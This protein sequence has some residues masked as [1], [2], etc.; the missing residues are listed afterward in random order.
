VA[1][2][3]AAGI[4]LP[5]QQRGVGYVVQDLALFPHMTVRDNIAFPL[6]GQPHAT[7]EHRVDELIDTM[8]LAGTADRRPAYISGGQQQRVALARALA[9]NPKLLLLDEPFS[10]LDSELQAAL[11]RE[12]RALQRR[13]QMTVLLVTH[14]IDEAFSM[15]DRVVA[16]HD[17]RVSQ[18]GTRE[19]VF[20][21]PR[22]YE[23]AKLV[24]VRNFI[25][26]D[27]SDVKAGA[28]TV[29]TRW[30][31]ATLPSRDFGRGDGVWIC[32]RPEHVIV[33]REGTHGREPGDITL[34]ADVIE[35]STLPMAHSLVARVA[36]ADGSLD[37]FIDVP[38]R[39][40][41]RLHLQSVATLGVVLPASRL[42]LV[43]R[44]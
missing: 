11:R 33:P 15:A 17:G 4:D 26:G 16:Y 36:S 41:E 5:P 10:A 30:F 13:L 19:E 35:D 20:Y 29:R 6:H 44:G 2:D 28:A 7:V 39:P 24:G 23:V 37:L 1:F 25:A 3:A 31:D 8:G 14:D 21:A 12:V 34:E 22:S 18:S 40:Y 32:I 42:F 27:V 43:P 38:A 9:A